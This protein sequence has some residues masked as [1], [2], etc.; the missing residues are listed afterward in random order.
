MAPCPSGSGVGAAHDEGVR[1]D[2]AHE[3]LRHRAQLAVFHGAH[4]EGAHHHQIVV[5][6]PT[7]LDEGLVVLA[8]HHLAL[9]GQARRLRLTTHDIE[10]GVRD[11]LQSHGDE[12]IVDLALPFQLVLVLVLLGQ[13]VLHLLEAVVVQTRRVHVTP[14][15]S[16]ARRPGRSPPPA[17][18]RGSSSP[19]CQRA[20]RCA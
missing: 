14:G 1:G 19:N 8:V 4:A 6:G 9:V 10:V 13:G 5:G 20:R 18:P 16:R 12:G 15:Q 17:P 11:E 3:A 2:L 7:V